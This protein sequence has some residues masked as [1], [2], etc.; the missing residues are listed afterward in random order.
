MKQFVVIMAIAIIVVLA[1]CAA[2]PSQQLSN[3]Q[4]TYLDT[5]ISID[6]D[7]A[8]VIAALGEPKTYTEET[9]CAFDGLDKTY[10]YGSFY[11]TTYPKGGADH[12]ARIWFA[13]DSVS[14]QEGIRIGSS[15]NE[16]E[17]AYGE[18]FGDKNSIAVIRKDSKLTIILEDGIVASL[19][20]ALIIE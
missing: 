19:Q 12:V 17:Q 11:L 3:F 20:Y 2:S 9:S 4:F 1:G 7:A 18:K 5:V 15:R 13:D 8:P 10:N 14:T 16:V 6:A